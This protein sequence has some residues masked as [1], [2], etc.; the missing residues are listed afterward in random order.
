MTVT[1]IRLRLRGEEKIKAYAA[2]T[3]D[4][5]FIVRD[6]KVI[7]GNNGLFVA[8]PSRRRH[9]GTHKDVAHPLDVSTRN[10]IEAKILDAYRLATRTDA[11]PAPEF[12]AVGLPALEEL[13]QTI[14]DSFNK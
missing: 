3:F 4:H 2:V 1:D 12:D 11:K 6:I 14:E 9:D 5:C 10:M 13:D 7:Q 8:M